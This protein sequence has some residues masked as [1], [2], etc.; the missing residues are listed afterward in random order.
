MAA[1]RVMMGFGR[2]PCA[3]RRPTACTMYLLR[4]PYFGV[5]NTYRFGWSDLIREYHPV[6]VAHRRRIVCPRQISPVCF[7]LS[8]SHQRVWLASLLL[9]FLGELFIYPY[10]VALQFQRCW[11]PDEFAV[12]ENTELGDNISL[13]SIELVRFSHTVY[14]FI[15][16]FVKNFLFIFQKVSKGVFTNL[17]SAL[18]D[19]TKY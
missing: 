1:L 7:P 8:Q 15:G 6:L 18:R 12:F 13:P 14:I 17:T 11:L 2:C 19:T 9:Y 3:I 5:S 16:N 4:S 10:I